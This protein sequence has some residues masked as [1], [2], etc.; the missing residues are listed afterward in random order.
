MVFNYLNHAFVRSKFKAINKM[1]RDELKRAQD[2]YNDANDAHISLVD[3]WDLFFKKHIDKMVADGKT[4]VTSAISAMRSQWSE[5]NNP[6][7]TAYQALALEVNEHLDQLEKS[8]ITDG[9]IH[10][11]TSDMY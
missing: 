1:M 7:D 4:W 2:A 6:T 5:L 9:G 8:G 3:C 11:D 10:F